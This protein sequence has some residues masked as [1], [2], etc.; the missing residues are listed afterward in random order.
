M[1]DKQKIKQLSL[2]NLE[3]SKKLEGNERTVRRGYKSPKL[4]KDKVPLIDFQSFAPISF[5]QE[6]MKKANEF[7]VSWRAALKEGR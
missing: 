1:N 2:E 6:F 4:K 3:L 7:S 5:H